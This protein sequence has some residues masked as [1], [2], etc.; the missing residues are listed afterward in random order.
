MQDARQRA[1]HWGAKDAVVRQW[2]S[3]AEL[4][5][6]KIRQNFGDDGYQQVA[7]SVNEVWQTHEDNPNRPLHKPAPVRPTN[8]GPSGP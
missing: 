8:S 3:F 7:D 1:D 6:E 2:H 5:K 4:I